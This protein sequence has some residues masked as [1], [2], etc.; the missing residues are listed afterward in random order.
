MMTMPFFMRESPRRPDAV[1]TIRQRPAVPDGLW[2][3]EITAA[4]L[5]LSHAGNG[6]SCPTAVIDRPQLGR[7]RW[8]ESGESLRYE[9]PARIY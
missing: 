8:V 7:L 2:R 1:Y 5:L 6:S 3:R 9:T 4:S